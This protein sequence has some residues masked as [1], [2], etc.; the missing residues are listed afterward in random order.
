MKYSCFPKKYSE[1]LSLKISHIFYIDQKLFFLFIFYDA[2]K[3]FKAQKIVFTHDFPSKQID[4]IKNSY[5]YKC[6]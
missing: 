1:K 6:F 3:Y 2:T 4:N 5:I